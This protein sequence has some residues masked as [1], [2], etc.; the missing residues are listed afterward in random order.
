M[1]YLCEG[2]DPCVYTLNP[3]RPR[4]PYTYRKTPIISSQ[5]YIGMRLHLSFK[6]FRSSSCLLTLIFTGLILALGALYRYLESEQV[7]LDVTSYAPVA[8][9][10]PRKVL[11]SNSADDRLKTSQLEYS[12]HNLH[13]SFSINI[14]TAYPD[15]LGGSYDA[16]GLEQTWITANDRFGPHGHGENHPE[17]SRS[18]VDWEVIDWAS[19]QDDCLAVNKHR[20]RGATELMS[21][22]KLSPS[23]WIARLKLTMQTK[24]SARPSITTGRTAIV[25]RSWSGHTYGQQDMIFL[26]SLIVEA[27]L[28]S[29]SEYAVYLLIDVKEQGKEMYSSEADY[30]SVLEELVPKEFQSIAVLFNGQ[31]LESWYPKVGEHA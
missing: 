11:L 24:P 29:G 22:S 5:L 16:L 26:R 3:V 15:T 18:R 10:G 13:D 17:Y 27:A 1:F 23:G 9:I 31:L 14:A 30:R 20:F 12:T 7:S 4:V 2:D 25:I 8:C 6:P 19:L 28:S 21:P